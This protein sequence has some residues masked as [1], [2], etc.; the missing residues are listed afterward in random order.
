[1]IFFQELNEHLTKI[2]TINYRHLSY[3]LQKG[4]YATLQQANKTLKVT[5]HNTLH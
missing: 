1:M 5:L 2:N 4:F 3:F